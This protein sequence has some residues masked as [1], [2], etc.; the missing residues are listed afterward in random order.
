MNSNRLWYHAIKEYRNAVS[1]RV[2]FYGLKI[3]KF[4]CY[5]FADHICTSP[6]FH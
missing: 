4:F 3:S 6:D 1:V 5:L 2:Q